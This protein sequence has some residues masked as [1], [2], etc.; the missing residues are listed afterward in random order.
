MNGRET[1]LE[2]AWWHYWRGDYAAMSRCLADIAAGTLQSPVRLIA[3]W[4]SDFQAISQRRKH[5]FD[6]DNFT[7]LTAWNELLYHLLKIENAPVVPAPNQQKSDSFILYRILGSDLPPRHYTGQ[8]LA[9][10][11]FILNHEPPLHRCKKAW[12]VNRIIDAQQ[13]QKILETLEAHHQTYRHIPFDE[14]EYAKVSYDFE[15][16][17]EADF[18]RSPTFQKLDRN[19]QIWACDRPYRPKNLAAIN[20][21]AVRNQILDEGQQIADWTMVLDGGCFITHNAWRSLLS[22]QPGYK[23]IIIPMVRL[24]HNE[25]LFTPQAIP[26]PTEEPQIA[27]HKSSQAR[28]DES[29]QYG[30]FTKV[31]LF[32]QLKVP[33]VWDKWNYKPWENKHWRISPEAGQWTKLGRVARLSSG[34]S[35]DYDQG[36][37]GL[38]GRTV[39]RQAAVWQFI[40]AIDERIFRRRFGPEKLLFF[41]AATLARC[42]EQYQRGNPQAT[43]L[44]Q[45]LIQLANKALTHPAY[46][47]V[48]KADLPPSGDRHDYWSLAAFSWPDPAQPD[49]LPYVFRDGMRS[50]ATEL[51][52]TESQQ[53]DHTRLQLTLDN[54][55]VLALAWYMT[56][57]IDYALHAA[58]LVRT[59]FLKPA[60]RMNPNLNYAQVELGKNNNQGMRWGVI[61]TKDFYYFLDAVRLL[62]QS[63]AWSAPDQRAMQSWCKKLLSW[64]NESKQGRLERCAVNN[65][66]TCYDLQIAAL[67]G[68]CDD[69]IALSKTLEYS[70]MR[71]AKQF[72]PNGQQPYELKRSATLHYC[73]FNLQSWA[74]LAKMAEHVGIDLWHYSANNGACLQA[75]FEWLLPY[76]NQPWP[77]R[78]I[79]IFEKERLLPL[80]QIACEVYP[81][82]RENS[83]LG[84]IPSSDRIAPHAY[85][86][87]APGWMFAQISYSSSSLAF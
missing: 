73:T 21:N 59:W 9:N 1:K 10:L 26:A 56:G 19:S 66:G 54:T 13:E 50:P 69:A 49:G 87:I 80:Y 55:T 25:Q 28:F 62:Q 79:K 44:A 77:Y 23:Q 18:L 82:V 85:F 39:D 36:N 67:S 38:R 81:S 2:V 43:R 72:L 51:Y 20:L 71:I 46:S 24:T 8:T 35:L 41:N 33:G 7:N 52:S 48:Q 78:Q 60:T 34:H 47:V 42:R 37:S 11:Q 64:L 31:E 15:S 27:L 30:R 16:F 84:S 70:K 76:Y 63:D 65:H 4:L 5:V 57:N 40:D 32:R 75:A 53:Y 6:V 86:G 68:F 22:V 83:A 74:N 29:L 14:D 61:D 45:Q 17:L 58:E 3:D 12:V